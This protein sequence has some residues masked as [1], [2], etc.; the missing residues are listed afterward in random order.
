MMPLSARALKHERCAPMTTTAV[1][2][3]SALSHT[4]TSASRPRPPPPYIHPFG[5]RR[6]RLHV[7]I[8][9]FVLLG[10]QSAPV[11]AAR[12][13]RVNTHMAPLWPPSPPGMTPACTHLPA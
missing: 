2:S 9:A 4:R 6:R 3:S 8:I 1:S 12:L 7:G 11:S 10:D 13:Q 5:R